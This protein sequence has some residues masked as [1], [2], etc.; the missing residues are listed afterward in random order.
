MFD[1]FL[2]YLKW[3]KNRSWCFTVSTLSMAISA[4][5]IKI[6]FIAQYFNKFTKLWILQFRVIELRSFC[7]LVQFAFVIIWAVVEKTSL[8]SFSVGYRMSE[9][10]PFRL[11]C[12][13]LKFLTRFNRY[14]GMMALLSEILYFIYVHILWAS[15]EWFVEEYF[16]GRGGLFSTK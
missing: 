10:E 16:S 2:I 14:D 7:L 12:L 6:F 8:I 1:R 5:T 9:D 13:K 3:L 4:H 15:S 11:K